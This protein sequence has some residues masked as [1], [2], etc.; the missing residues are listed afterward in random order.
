MLSIA[1]LG[2]I[3]EFEDSFDGLPGLLG[4]GS[5]EDV[6]A[7]GSW[8]GR[9]SGGVLLV[10]RVVVVTWEDLGRFVI[11]RWPTIGIASSTDTLRSRDNNNDSAVVSG[12]SNKRRNKARRSSGSGTDDDSKVGLSSNSCR[13]SGS[14]EGIEVGSG[15][16]GGFSS[17]TSVCRNT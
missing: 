3:L 5:K 12:L 7:I 11:T 13:A 15:T 8:A 9:G 4:S 14:A 6:V 2:D 17:S 16:I 10:G 1:R